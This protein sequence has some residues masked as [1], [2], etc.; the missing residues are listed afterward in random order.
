[1]S[2]FSQNSLEIPKPIIQKDSSGI[3]LIAFDKEGIDIIIKTLKEQN[4]NKKI[5]NQLEKK[6]TS[7]YNKNKI[8]KEKIDSLNKNIENYI[9]ITINNKQEVELYEKKIENLEQ[10][11][12]DYEK[13]KT[14]MSII[15]KDYKNKIKRKNGH[16]YKLIGTNIVTATLLII[17][18][19]N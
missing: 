3:T 10:N 9:Q 5:I 1:M 16:I 6:S 12:I 8:Y 17:V 15:I 2:S 18:L 14:N 11:I 4:I 19:L 7:L 13:Q